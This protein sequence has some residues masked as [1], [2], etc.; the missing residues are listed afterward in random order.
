MDFFA[1]LRYTLIFFQ[2]FPQKDSS[3]PAAAASPTLIYVRSDADMFD[4]VMADCIERTAPK[5]DLAEDLMLSPPQ[6]RSHNIYSPDYSDD[7]SPDDDS[8]QRSAGGAIMNKGREHTSVFEVVDSLM[9]NGML[10]VKVADSADYDGSDVACFDIVSSVSNDV[11]VVP[12]GVVQLSGNT[13]VI[14]GGSTIDLFHPAFHSSSDIAGAVINTNDANNSDFSNARFG[15]KMGDGNAEVGTVE[16]D[17]G[18]VFTANVSVNIPSNVGHVERTVRFSDDISG[19]DSEIVDVTFKKTGFTQDLFYKDSDVPNTPQLT[20][21]FKGQMGNETGL[22][23]DDIFFNLVTD[24]SSEPVVEVA[25]TSSLG[26][27]SGIFDVGINDSRGSPLSGKLEEAETST[28]AAGDQDDVWAKYL[29]DAS[30][31]KGTHGSGTDDQKSS[32]L[33]PDSHKSGSGT[34]DQKSSNLSTDPLTKEGYSRLVMDQENSVQSSYPTD[35][36][37]DTDTVLSDKDTRVDSLTAPDELD[38]KNTSLVKTMDD[39]VK[40]AKHDLNLER[41]ALSDTSESNTSTAVTSS[42][43][44]RTLVRL[45]TLRHPLAQTHSRHPPVQCTHSFDRFLWNVFVSPFV[46]FVQSFSCHCLLRF[47]LILFVFLNF[48][49]FKWHIIFIDRCLVHVIDVSVSF[50]FLHFLSLLFYPI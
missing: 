20:D 44:G 49:L 6:R 36:F 24:K 5:A 26:V 2:P 4:D 43:T 40:L 27:T 14:A 41:R 23:K 28:V 1:D 19:K 12:E 21:L 50:L 48:V 31:W 18:F 11:P 16:E 42:L 7:L 46:F 29:K 33:A 13:S 17:L 10:N 32:N 8:P 38:K 3:L 45:Y 9:S 34:D 47:W 30:D 35:P 39:D 22:M 37:N 15:Q 25:R